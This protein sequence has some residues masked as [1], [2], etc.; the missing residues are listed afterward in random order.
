[1]LSLSNETEVALT[2]MVIPSL[3]NFVQ[4]LLDYDA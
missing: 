1:M 3:D 4:T 2:K